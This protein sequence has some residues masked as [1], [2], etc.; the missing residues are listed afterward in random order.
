M[1]TIAVCTTFDSYADFETAKNDY[2]NNSFIICVISHSEKLKPDDPRYVKLQYKKINFICKAGKIIKSKQQ[3][4]RESSTGRQGCPFSLRIAIN[5]DNKLE[6]K[7]FNPNHENHSC[8]KETFLHYSESMRLN[9][10]EEKVA[11]TNY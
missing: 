3:G 7:V 6:I 4:I 10:D 1:N 8:D 2:Q 11:K 5:K 9:K